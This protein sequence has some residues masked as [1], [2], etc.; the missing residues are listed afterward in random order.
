MAPFWAD[1]PGNPNS[2]HA[3][4]IKARAAVT[5]A[6]EIIA[7]L[8]G[9]DDPS[10]IVFTSGATEANNWVISLYETGQM[11]PFEHPSVLEPGTKKGYLMAPE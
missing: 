10:Q 4:G 6:R 3:F 9:A 2:I 11:T 5:E 8:I 1:V 7:E